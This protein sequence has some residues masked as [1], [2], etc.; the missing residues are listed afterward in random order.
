M[1]RHGGVLRIAR[2]QAEAGTS[3][4]GIAYRTA[5]Y[6]LRYYTKNRWTDTPARMVGTVLTGTF[7]ASNLFEAV[8]DDNRLP[9]DYLLTTQL[10]R[11]EQVVPPHGEGT[12]ELQLRLQLIQLPQRRLLG[13]WL[14]DTSVPT[15]ANNATA[16]VA[17]SNAALSQAV[18]VAVQSVATALKDLPS[19]AGH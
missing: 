10:R 2:P 6:Q 8:I 18:A 4:R 13:S 3:T 11:L 7:E 16:A 12:V 19:S 1:P 15:M 9:A 14:I 17:A 5:P